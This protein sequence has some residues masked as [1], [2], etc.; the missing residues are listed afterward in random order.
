M[1]TLRR[2]LGTPSR[3]RETLWGYVFLA[4]FIVGFF[5]WQAYPLLLSLYYSFTDYDLLQPET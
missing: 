3:R 5:L 4:P 2:L 1:S